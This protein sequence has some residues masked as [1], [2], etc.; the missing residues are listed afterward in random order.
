MRECAASGPT[1]ETK[2]AKRTANAIC[3]D[4]DAI[5][6]CWTT[7]QAAHLCVGDPR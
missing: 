4:A 3:K 2:Q 5:G 7:A 1:T 6:T